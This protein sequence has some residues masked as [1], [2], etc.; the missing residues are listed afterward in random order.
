MASFC[1]SLPKILK[2]CP[3]GHNWP[4]PKGHMFY[5]ELYKDNLKI[6]LSETIRVR[7]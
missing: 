1:G 6:F 2:V 4:R 7:A 3:W 5:I